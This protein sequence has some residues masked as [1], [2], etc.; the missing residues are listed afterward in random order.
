MSFI[1]F[2]LITKEAGLRRMK[3]VLLDSII[4]KQMLTLQ[5]PLFLM[6]ICKSNRAYVLSLIGYVK[7]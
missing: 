6:Q 4:Y 2:M 1:P 3:I 7:P 5:I